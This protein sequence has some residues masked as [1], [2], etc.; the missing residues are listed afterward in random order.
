MIEI[1]SN[2]DNGTIKISEVYTPESTPD[3][4]SIESE[5]IV[6]INNLEN[7][8]S[9]DKFFYD[10]IGITD[11]RLLLNYYRISRDGINWSDWLDLNHNIT[12]FP[13]VNSKDPMYIDIKWVR[14]GTNPNGTIR[15]LEYSLDGTLERNI[16]DDTTSTT[17][18]NPKDNIILKTPFIYKVFSISD[19][20][21]IASGILDIKYRYSQDNSRTW[22]N[23]EILTKENITTTKINPIRFFQIEYSVTNNGDETIN[24]QDINLIGDYQNVSKDYFKTNMI[25]IR[26][27]CLSNIVGYF[28]ENGNYISPD[29]TDTTSCDSTS[30]L[31]QLSEQD[32]ANL[33][34]PYQQNAALEMYN[35]V[36][37][38]AEQIYG[39]RV[40]Y[41]LTDPDKKGED[42][43]LHEYQLYNVV[44][45]NYLKVAVEDNKFPDS[46]IVM[47]QFD[48][49]LFESMVVNVT[50]TQFKEV[51]G[52]QRRPGKEDFLYFCDINRIFQVDHA[53][54][55][56]SF[57]N[58]AIYYKLVLKK[59]NQKANVQAGTQDIKDK[60][61][62]LTNNS[63]INELFGVENKQDQE[64][65]AN[66]PQMATLTVDK[67]RLEY[68]AKIGRE[69]I[70]NSSTIISKSYY[71]LSE[72]KYQEVAVKYKNLKP[73]LEV[74]DNLGYMLWFNI[75]NYIPTESYN[76]MNYY[77]RNEGWK[78]NLENDKIKVVLNGVTYDFNVN[79][80]EEIWYCYILN[81]DQRNRKIEQF[82]YKR[83]VD[84]EEDAGKLTNNLLK[85]ITSDIKDI[86]PIQYYMENTNFEILGSDMKITNI[87]LFNEIIPEEQHNKICNQY[88]IRDDSKYLVFAD[89]A[90]DKI[91]LPK[92]PLNE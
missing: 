32:K 69:L 4:V 92:F 2:L 88:I 50:K 84:F 67:I 39:H 55:F 73:N 57:N 63:T 22:S 43:T 44:C 72:V 21:I 18:L 20:E 68:K 46:Q 29:N 3:L 12:N 19:V 40:L 8:I 37:V 10:T 56:R 24:L 45:N 6:S 1:I 26:E 14:V 31:P 13:D 62:M 38:D 53:Q 75:N 52:P 54:Q 33:Y 71:D 58:S 5:Y 35:K 41:F 65:V 30:Q 81:I 16:V 80:D 15:I 23:W 79:V 9:I 27:C 48:L 11:T 34:N 51:F 7:V 86:T 28:D 66:K 36:S 77:D 47:N 87:R 82:L 49:S 64:A 78:V 83:N 76:F 89:N 70:E 74:F 60:I 17:V 91:I 90:I 42:Q 61:N 85:K 59:Y 25:G